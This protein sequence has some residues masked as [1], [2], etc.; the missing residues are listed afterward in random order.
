MSVAEKVKLIEQGGR[1][2]K[3]QD[4]ANGRKTRVGSVVGGMGAWHIL[5]NMVWYGVNTSLWFLCNLR[6]REAEA[7]LKGTM[8]FWQEW[9]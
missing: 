7:G 6:G 3:N 2:G 4:L 9:E 5:G 1:K 8:K